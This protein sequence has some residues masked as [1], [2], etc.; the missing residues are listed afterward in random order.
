[1]CQKRNSAQTAA[2]KNP[3]RE[4]LGSYVLQELLSTQLKPS[5][6]F[7][8]T[9]SQKLMHKRGMID[10]HESVCHALERTVTAL[11][12]TD[13]VLNGGTLDHSF[14]SNVID[15][16]NRGTIVFGTAIL[17]NAGRPKTAT[18]ACTILPLPLHN[19]LLDLA[20]FRTDS[21]ATLG[22]LLGT[23]YDLSALPSPAQT[24]VE[25]NAI[26]DE[27]NQLLVLGNKRPA[28]SM[29]TLRADH[30]DIINF[31]CAK[32]EANFSEWRCNIS[33]FATEQL[34][35]CAATD[36]GWPLRDDDNNIVDEI[37][38]K[39]LL[40]EI[41]AS[42]HYC[43]E[44]GILFKDR[45]EEDNPTPHWSYKSTAP[46]AEI[47]MAEGE[48]CQFSYINLAT[49]LGKD[50]FFDAD[51]FGNAVE[52]VTRLLDASIDQTIEQSHE[53]GLSLVAQK[54]RIGVGIM[55]FADLLV[56]MKIPYDCEQAI[57]LATQISELLDYHSKHAS[58][59]LA[60]QRGSFP[61]YKLSKFTDSEWAQ[62]KLT[63]C[64]GA[65]PS[66]KWDALFTNL[67][68]FGIRHA[69]TTALPPTGTSSAL[70]G[71]SPSLE[72]LFALTDSQG[73]LIPSV[74]RALAKENSGCAHRVLKELQGPCA[75]VRDE[76]ILAANP[77]LRTAR[78]IGPKAHI[79]I[80]CAFQKFLDE[81]LA[82]TVNL[83][84]D[85]THEDVMQIL[86]ETYQNGLKGITVFRD[87]CLEERVT[88]SLTV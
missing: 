40:H 26:L 32:R 82:K 86:W 29:A 16:I 39:R 83:P 88:A 58:V 7:Y 68:E 41:A 12:K 75:I 27:I 52:H 54:R 21:L 3:Q 62:R 23:G 19:G 65:V 46:C 33:V 66:E 38:A 67:Q 20:R 60:K 63:H 71:A 14:A 61:A 51:L 69:S 34:F 24:L 25:L 45:M 70:V 53:L 17:T 6:E 47:A 78:Q 37:P 15:L 55:G 10:A 48:A 76:Q 11:I 80:Q 8:T 18:A 56:A 57:A 30:P 81:S 77:H 79:Q 74:R 73:E 85:A 36:N 84:H 42:A 44:P 1:M 2:H 35:I 87:G 50:G 13:L 49:C 64:T 72:P 31:I 22:N 28:A 5:S 43:G 4:A 59:E 9:A